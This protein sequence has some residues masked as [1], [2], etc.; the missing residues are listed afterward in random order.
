MNCLL[1]EKKRDQCRGCR[2]RLRRSGIE[3]ARVLDLRRR[4][5]NRTCARPQ[6]LKANGVVFEG[7]FEDRTL[8]RCM[9]LQRSYRT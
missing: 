3:H 2:S 8:K 1:L 5:R 9:R 7:K 6:Q 4:F